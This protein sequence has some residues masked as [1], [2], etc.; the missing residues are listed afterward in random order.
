MFSY[1]QTEQPLTPSQ[2]GIDIFGGNTNFP[3]IR[4]SEGDATVAALRNTLNIGSSF[5]NAN[6][7]TY[8]N[9]W[10]GSTSVN[11]IHGRHTIY[12]G[13]N[14]DHNQLN[15]V[16]NANKCGLRAVRILRRLPHWR[17]RSELNQ[18]HCGGQQ[19]LLSCRSGR[20]F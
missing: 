3:S 19:S 9:Q 16:N 4:I 2:V 13:A 11:W 5:S 14:W 18:F 12:A 6:A 1:V 20:R 8:Q 15:I 7:G 17:H 10:T